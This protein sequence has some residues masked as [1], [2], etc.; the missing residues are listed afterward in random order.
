MDGR[1]TLACG[2][3]VVLD[4]G[5]VSDSARAGTTSPYVHQK[6]AIVARARCGGMMIHTVAMKPL[7]SAGTAA[8]A[9]GLLLSACVSD[10]GSLFQ[11]VTPPAREVPPTATLE[12]QPAASDLPLPA[13]GAAAPGE[14]LIVPSRGVPPSAAPLPS[15]D[16]SPAAEPA[17]PAAAE[18][19]PSPCEAVG[20][21][22]CDT[23]EDSE[24]GQF[25]QGPGWLPE[26][27]GCG[28]HRID[29]AGPV[30]SGTHSMR[31]SDGGYPEC[32]LH[33]DVSG[34]AEV[35]VQ[36]RIFL[37][38]EETLLAEYTSLLEFGAAAS[39]DDPELRIG[40]RPS[41]DNL[42][43]GVPGLDVTGGGLDGGPRTACS[44]VELEPERW[45]C[46][47][48]HL[49]R[50]GRELS[51]S[52][53]LDGQALLEDTFAGAAG[54]DGAPLFVKV[55]RAA[56]GASSLGTLW[57]DDLVVSREPVPCQP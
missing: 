10:D 15:D 20:L 53:A 33:A 35:Y 29:D 49:S 51:L 22:A 34:E 2:V 26:L 36:T 24:A 11:G 6:L 48:A 16:G 19:A 17:E 39:T 40:I 28:T 9:A 55:G 54:W 18:P 12:A 31:V 42:C 37:G 4:K 21:L 23:F 32:M 44:G 5:R 1:A 50:R 52:L 7:H 27:A 56:Y 57:Y 38:A 30:F 43:N 8:A 13:S 45:Y 47:E 14:Q 3:L 46:V 41:V 25:P